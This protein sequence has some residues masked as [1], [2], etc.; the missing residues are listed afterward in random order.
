MRYDLS[1]KY[2]AQAAR[3]YF[4]KLLT[5]GSVIELSKVTRKRTL[6]QNGL[7]W[8]WLTCIERETGMRKEE[9]HLLYRSMFLWKSDDL[10]NKILRPNITERVKIRT[11]Q[12]DYFPELADIIDVV[13]RS[14]TD[15]DTAE[16][17]NYMEKMRDHASQEMGILLLTKEEEGFNQFLSEYGR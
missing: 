13:S 6:D 15:L 5:K 14:T 8:V 1:I 4:E 7:Y 11:S 17:T 12:F 16:M 2:K 10:I 3:E 9:L